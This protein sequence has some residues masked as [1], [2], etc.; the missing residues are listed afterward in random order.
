MPTFH[1]SPELCAMVSLSHTIPDEIFLILR[2][3]EE[4]LKPRVSFIYCYLLEESDVLLFNI[5]VRALNDGELTLYLE[6][7]R[8]EGLKLLPDVLPVEEEIP[9]TMV[10]GKSPAIIAKLSETMTIIGE[11]NECPIFQY[12][13][14]LDGFFHRMESW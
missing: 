9:N 5:F 11:C 6:Y 3:I 13:G 12:E 4:F 8:A 2:Q 1:S 7:V 10:I 14:T